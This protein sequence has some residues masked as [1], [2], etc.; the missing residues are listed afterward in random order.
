MKRNWFSLSLAAVL[1]LLLLAGCGADPAGP[2]DTA[3]PGNT[4]SVETPDAPPESPAESPAQPVEYDFTGL[5]LDE[6]TQS[7]TGFEGLPWGYA[8]PQELVDDLGGDEMITL[9][10]AVQ[11]AGLDFQAEQVFNYTGAVSGLTEDQRALTMGQY[12]RTGYFSLDDPEGSISMAVADFNQVLAYLIQ[13]YGSPTS[14]TV[15]DEELSGPLTAAQFG[16]DG[17]GDCLAAWEGLEGATVR[18]RLSGFYG[19]SIM[20]SFG[21]TAAAES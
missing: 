10:T 20:V 5:E 15:D 11:F 2:A 4:T 13:V 1:T 14:C 16:A 8:L 3:S 21:M 6:Y 12:V 7:L 17:T 9:R 19:G 18:L